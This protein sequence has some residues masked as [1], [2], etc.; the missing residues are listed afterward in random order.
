MHQHLF[1]SSINRIGIPFLILAFFLLGIPF[2][3]SAQGTR[4]LRQPSISETHITFSY[5]S[6]IWV[7][8][9]DGSQLRR[10]TNT[11]AI[12]ENPFL[13]PDGK[14]IAFSS[15][16]S[17][18]L[19]VYVVPIEGGMPQRLSW[20]PAAAFVRG[21]TPDGKNVLYATGRDFA[22]KPS[23][24]LWTIP[25]TGGNP[26]LLTAQ[27]GNDGAFSPDGS[28][29]ALDVVSRWD[30]EWR[31]Y[32]GGQNTPLVILNLTDQSE[33][34]I[35]NERTTDVQ[36]VWIGESV[37][38]LSDRDG[39][40]NIWNYSPATK[41]VKQITTYDGSDI[42]WLSG[43]DKLTFERDGYLFLMNPAT[44]EVQQ[45]IIDIRGDFPWAATAWEEVGKRATH[46]RLSP[47]GKRAIVEARGDI[48]TVPV[49]HG[50]ARNLTQSSDAADREPI[51]S[52]KGD[53]VAWF[54]D[55]GHQA[56]RLMI[57]AQ[58]GLSEPREI[59]IGV[60]KMAWNPVWSPDG[61]HIAFVDDDVRIR[62]ID[63][64][65]DSI[66]TIDTGGLNVERGSMEL[67]WAKDSKW[68]AYDKTGPN[69]FKSIWIWSLEDGQK[70]AVTNAFANAFS[71]TWDADGKHLYF[72]ASTDVALGTG[73]ANTSAMN[74]RAEYA[75]YVINLSKEDPS[76]FELRSDEEEVEAE[77]EEAEKPES[78]SSTKKKAKKPKKA[79]GEE[80]EEAAKEKKES[81]TIDFERIDRRTI[82]LPIPQR[83][84]RFM[85]AG[86]EGT[87]FIAERE[88]NKS[89]LKVSKFTLK[90]R[91]AEDFVSGVSYM[92]VSAD[93]KQ[94]LARVNGSWQVLDCAK[95]PSTAKK[96]DMSLQVKVD[97]AAEWKQIFEE[98]WR[99]E[100]DFF[101]DPDLHGRNWDQVYKRYAPLIPYVKHRHDLNYVLDQVNGEL[102]VGHSFVSGGD[103][104]EVAS[105]KVGLLGADLVTEDNRWKIQRIY[106]TEDWNPDLTSPLDQ[107]GANIQTAYYIV[108]VNGRE[109]SSSDNPFEML[110]GTVGKQ[111]V[112]HLNSSP[113]FASAWKEVVKPI[114]YRAELALRERAWVEDNRRLVDSLSNGQLAYVWVPNTS[115]QGLVSFNRYY[116]AQ[117]D[118]KGA[119]IDERFNGGGL[120]DDY[121]VDL[122]TRRLRAAYTNEVPNGKPGR[123]PAGILGPKV[124]LINEMAGSGGDFF[125][126][127]FR[128]QK[129]G[130]L[131]GKR[132]WGGLVK[133]STHYLMVDGGRVTAPDNAIFDPIKGEWIGENKG[134]APDIEVRQDAKA[135]AAGRDPQLERAVEELLK[136][137][138]A[139]AVEIKIPEFSTPAKQK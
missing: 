136:L 134:I 67:A 92:T 52:P 46:A 112:L 43:K 131:I 129:A 74:A 128:Q 72:L 90:E 1:T 91:K 44:Q 68:L 57:A 60:S 69:N 117:Q 118:K 106:T 111:T 11:P 61:K 10:I 45:L 126:W 20:H 51:W 88:E 13:S 6:D 4:L 26:T 8:R 115:G 121:M 22:P 102:S 120:L 55:K 94:V 100:K 96:L 101:Y 16:R 2:S 12:E 3:M 40:M 82:P 123:L 14:Q 31:A 7:S 53:Q 103:Y 87:V 56:Y 99:Y 36:P 138:E 73:W 75:A 19:A 50:D 24:R 132:T 71:P 125:P 122:I 27:R 23:N 139:E 38:F 70:R 9:L 83:M 89:G 77:K 108:G 39:V 64:E 47:H 54:S 18:T 81:I 104:P 79:K 58:D 66:Q 86:P 130:P 133:S 109:L 93:R 5:G 137:L 41:A 80:A 110:D 116:F 29:I 34:L 124:L 30:E 135:L 59:S 17:G 78:D 105:A 37:Y 84:Y 65:T 113:D 48:Y 21:W 25:A 62:V 127:V 107:P 95:P 28:R 85:L 49:E 76:P 32:R 114:S 119:V 35:P 98:T 97:R 33:E 42:K 15:N 63:L